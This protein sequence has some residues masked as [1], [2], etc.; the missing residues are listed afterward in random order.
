MGDVTNKTIVALLAVALVVTVVGT[1]VSVSKLSSLGATYTLLTGSA[2]S[3]T[4]TTELNLGANVGLSVVD[5]AIDW[6][7]GQYNGIC[8]EGYATINSDNSAA[9]CW[10]NADGTGT[11]SAVNDPH[12]ISNEGNS[13]SKVMVAFADSNAEVFLCNDDCP[14]SAV[15]LVT[16]KSADSESGSCTGNTASAYTTL[17][18]AT[19]TAATVTLCSN[20]NTDADADSIEVNYELRVPGDAIAGAKSVTVTYTAE[21]AT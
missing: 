1:A 17:A 6:G 5:T 4:G 9:T 18:S 15:A 16:V 8:T 14:S 2:T 13:P 19:G 11:A 20:L 21:A 7:P 12:T 3:D 10:L